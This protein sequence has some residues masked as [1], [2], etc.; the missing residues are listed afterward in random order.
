[1]QVY[2]ALWGLGIGCGAAVAFGVCQ[3]RGL[4]S[5]AVASV[6]GMA[7]VALFIG[8]RL[9]YRI[10]SMPLSL[11]IRIP[12]D[13]VRASGM[14]LPLGMVLAG[15]AAAFGCA[16]F[17]L[18]WPEVGDALAVGSMVAT[19]IGRIGC[20]LNGCC[21]GFVCP[22]WMEAACVRPWPGSEAFGEQLSHDSLF[23][24]TSLSAVVPL[25]LLFSVL[26][27]VIL[28]VLVKLLRSRWPPGTVLLTACL[29]GSIGKLILE[30]V[31]A[32]PR[33]GVLHLGIPVATAIV[34]VGVL[35]ARRFASELRAGPRAHASGVAAVGHPSVVEEVERARS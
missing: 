30:Q 27:V 10:E 25:P 31:R 7:C 9:Q 14:R 6:I 8:A 3:H 24:P 11:A 4:R 12:I 15:A 33:P 16:L 28:C 5:P 1:M 35:L 26:S 19:A 34:S 22:S 17:R 23:Q 2:P 21:M 32:V 29:L 18:P 13:S 20:F